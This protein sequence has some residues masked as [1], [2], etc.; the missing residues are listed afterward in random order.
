MK[1]NF[2]GF[3]EN[4]IPSK[5][6]GSLIRITCIE[7]LGAVPCGAQSLLM[8]KADGGYSFELNYG[9]F[10]ME[11]KHKGSHNFIKIGTFL[12]D[13]ET[14]SD[15]IMSIIID[16]KKKDKAPS[17]AA[18]RDSDINDLAGDLLKLNKQVSTI[19]S[20]INLIKDALNK[21]DSIYKK[22]LDSALK[23]YT[24]IGN[25]N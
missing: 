21:V 15:C 3:I 19:N 22:R 20:E 10:L 13:G 23:T 17:K 5:V 25:G 1:K 8:T 9:R 7:T 12:V 16:D 18:S 24:E 2:S 4:P 14:E 11:M 6:G